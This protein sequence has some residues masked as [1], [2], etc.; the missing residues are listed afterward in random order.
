MIA[1]MRIRNYST[2]LQPFFTHRYSSK[3]CQI[4]LDR[5]DK[6]SKHLGV[7]HT[8]HEKVPP[9]ERLYQENDSIIMRFHLNRIAQSVGQDKYCKHRFRNAQQ[10]TPSLQSEPSCWRTSK[11]R[12][13][14]R[15][16]AGGK[17]DNSA[18]CRCREQAQW[19]GS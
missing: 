4:F 15:K 2:Q 18:F 13:A 11:L 19:N 10:D 1:I 14:N 8:F 9:A 16:T 5:P 12:R 3:T 7:S 6:E 17:S